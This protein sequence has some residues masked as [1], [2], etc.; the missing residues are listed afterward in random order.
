MILRQINPKARGEAQQVGGYWHLH[1]HL[2]AGGLFLVPIFSSASPSHPVLT[3]ACMQLHMDEAVAW[4]RCLSLNSSSRAAT[5]LAQR[6]AAAGGVG[7]IGG[8]RLAAGPRQTRV[9]AAERREVWR[10]MQ[11]RMEGE[12]QPAPFF[13]RL[14]IDTHRNCS[15]PAYRR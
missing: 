1:L 6:R 9:P 12:R 2:D 8:A 3:P 5:L 14:L 13:C 10:I 4:M 15:M 11:V 7:D